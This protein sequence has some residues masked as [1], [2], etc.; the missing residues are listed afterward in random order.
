[1][2]D[3]GTCLRFYKRKDVQ[4]AIVA[5]ARNKEVGVRYGDGFGKRPDVIS[6]PREVLELAMRGV[7]SFHA[8]EER[9]ENPLDL[10]SNHGRKDLDELRTGWDLV[11]DIDCIDW[12]LAKLTTHLFIK[13]LKENGVDCVSCKFS[14]NKGFHIGVPFEAFPSEIGGQKTENL[15]P[16]AAQKISHYLLYL[17]TKKYTIKDNKVSFSEKHTYSLDKLKEK[18]GEKE[19]I[20]N[21]CKSCNKKINFEIEDFSEFICPRCEKK[22]K[23]KN[24]FMKC[25]KCDIIME[26]IENKKSLCECGSNDYNSNFDPKSILEVDTVLISSRHLYRM[27]YSLHEKSGLASL[28]IDPDK[29]MEFEKNMAHPDSILAPMFSFM[30]RD[31]KG[32][33]A[34]RLLVQALD[35]E[36]K[37][38]EEREEKKDFE[39]IEITSPIT[40]DFFPP[41][42]KI[43][44]EGLQDGKKRGIFA[45]MNFLGKIG[46]SKKEIE[47]YLQK[48]NKEKNSEPLREVYIKGQMHSFKPGD[49]LPPNCNNEAYYQGIGI[50]KPDGL[51]RRIK[52]PVNYTIYRW[53]RHLQDNESNKSN[54]K[55]D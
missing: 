25:D 51:C 45:M 43:I 2:L 29:V 32:E 23:S 35:F 27:P 8:S 39:E 47:D 53:R 28:P 21:T 9:W 16:L 34:R 40:E 1:M 46:W 33:S 14:G 26:K 5:H 10:D 19:F 11:L 24:D 55:D 31:V 50:C 15:F 41:C 37:V 20:T 42:M 48:W 36:V 6:Y 12:E 3:K 44:L 13:A 49:K 4:D 17:I 30:D 7:T 18:F 52:N 22:E 38:E 54:K